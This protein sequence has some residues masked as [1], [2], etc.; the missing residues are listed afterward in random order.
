MVVFDMDNTLVDEFGATV[1]PQ[2][3]GLLKK[4]SRSYELVLWTNSAQ[5]RAKSILHEHALAQYFKKII[6][7]EDYD[8]AMKDLP[9]DLRKIGG[10]FIV[11][12]DP[13][14]VEFN[15]KNKIPGFCISAYRKSMAGRDYSG[16]LRSLYA[17]IVKGA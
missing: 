5:G 3:V 13:K 10:R 9:K 8:P 11:D 17:A 12:D 2:M 15:K 7:R 4:L 6:C 16:E 1:R 14:E